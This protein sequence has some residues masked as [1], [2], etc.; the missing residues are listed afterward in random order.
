MEKKRVTLKLNGTSWRY[1]TESTTPFNDPIFAFVTAPKDGEVGTV[2]DMTYCRESFC[3]YIRQELRGV[4]HR[5]ID[6]RKIHMVVFRR[7]SKRKL[8]GAKDFQNQ[9]V[10]AQKMLNVIEKNYGWP[11]TKIYPAK[12]YRKMAVNNKFYYVTAS[13]RWIK[14]P[15]ML[16]LFTL[17]F[18]VAITETKHKFK[19]KI[20]SMKSLFAVLD[21]L[22]A[23][24]GQAEVL[25]Y[26][27]HGHNWKLVLSNYAKLFG[28][29]SMS[30]LYFPKAG[31]YFFTEGINQLCDGSS[32]DETLN[33]QFDKLTAGKRS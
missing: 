31:G 9:I 14:A 10:A 16:S 28:S 22:S 25:Y 27:K 18:R 33:K 23:R 4:A 3:E 21:D 13:K 8:M 24:S 2:T 1:V 30:D 7:I 26:G 17:L 5:G 32:K 15:A 20:R 11:L 19:N 29:R 6:L 12:S